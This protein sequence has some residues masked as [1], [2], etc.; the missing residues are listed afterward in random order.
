ML[1][2]LVS[3]RHVAQEDGVGRRERVDQALERRRSVLLRECLSVQ[4]VGL[5]VEGFRA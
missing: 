1:G 2:S 5:R 3:H 4:G